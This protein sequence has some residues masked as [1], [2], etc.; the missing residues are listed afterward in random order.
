MAKSTS[1]PQN[2]G[3]ARSPHAQRP[4]CWGSHRL[5]LDCRDHTRTLVLSP[6]IIRS[7]SPWTSLQ[8]HCMYHQLRQWAICKTGRKGKNQWAE[9]SLISLE[10]LAKITLNELNK[11]GESKEQRLRERKGWLWSLNLLGSGAALGHGG[12]E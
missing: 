7:P 4:V 6:P 9:Y 12:L 5:T 11:T 3:R 8:S 1:L 2:L 10:M